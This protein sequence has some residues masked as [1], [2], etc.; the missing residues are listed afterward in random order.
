V[1]K[2]EKKRESIK[3]S[4]INDSIFTVE[5]LNG[6]NEIKQTQSICRSHRQQPSRKGN[7]M[8]DGKTTTTTTISQE[9]ERSREG[10][11]DE[12]RKKESL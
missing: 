11:E 5:D 2:T 9:E 12:E 6:K 8:T 1:G 3:P 10:K 4:N 7:P